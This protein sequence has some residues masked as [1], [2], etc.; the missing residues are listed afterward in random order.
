MEDLMKDLIF[1]YLDGR[2]K[3]DQVQTLQD[4]INADEQNART[5]A[6]YCL[7]HSHMRTQCMEEDLR[8]SL[9]EFTQTD[10]PSAGEDTGSVSSEVILGV[11][12]PESEAKV[13]R[14]REFAEQELQTYMDEQDRLRGE[15]QSQPLRRPTAW[16][17]FRHGIHERFT[18]LVFFLTAYSRLVLRTWILVSVILLLGLVI[19]GQY[20]QRV[21]ATLV[22]EMDA[23]WVKAPETKALR[24]GTLE[25]R[26]GFAEIQFNNQVTVLLEAPCRL[27]LH[28]PKKMS[29]HEGT[30]TARVPKQA[31]GFTVKTASS[32]VVD[33]GTE[34]GVRIG[35]DGKT[36]AAVFTGRLRFSSLHKSPT[37]G[38]KSLI[39]Q[40]NQQAETS[41]RGTL[42]GGV[43]S[44]PEDHGYLLSWQD[45]DDLK[46]RQLHERL[47][48]P[49]AT[50]QCRI[51]REKPQ[52]LKKGSLASNEHIFVFLERHSITLAEDWTGVVVTPGLV[53][54]GKPLTTRKV[55]SAGSQVDSYIVHLNPE[56]GLQARIECRA[57][58]VFPRPIVGVVTATEQLNS[59]DVLFGDPAID[60]PGSGRGVEAK[61]A[62]A[63]EHEVMIGAD[64]Q[65]LHL[66]MAA[67][68]RLD[69]MRVLIQ[70]VQTSS[71]KTN[72]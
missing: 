39:V 45:V 70:A 17:A 11:G 53:D 29:L 12:E 24:P 7:V 36:Q 18:H 55:L 65:T 20:R 44:L 3:P 59:T 37:L 13:Q 41:A 49:Q 43:Q 9:T 54:L 19:H 66:N 1:R 33:L 27:D 58:V 46:Q 32:R 23:V 40:K 35:E 64:R 47:Y 22:E 67:Y 6:R 4:W 14:I 52:S 42:T 38:I 57:T 63:E 15:Q 60:Y 30:L 31:V 51:L 2:L 48:L 34:F 16:Q 25:L 10:P 72:E 56:E 68:S 71:N 8:E 21:I 28:S 5:F 61:A 62:T 26:Q 69:Q 50:G